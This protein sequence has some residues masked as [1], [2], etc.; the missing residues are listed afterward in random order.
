M[1]RQKK[2]IDPLRNRLVELIDA[3]VA[4]AREH[5]QTAQDIA[6]LLNAADKTGDRIEIDGNVVLGLF[7]KDGGN[8]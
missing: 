4:A 3:E 2:I 7:V 8:V 1:A 5:L 6:E